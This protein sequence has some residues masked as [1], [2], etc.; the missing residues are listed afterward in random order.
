MKLFFKLACL[1][2]AAA[3][4]A[5]AYASDG[6]VTVTGSVSGTT[7]TIVGNGT[8][9]TG[10]FTVALPKV[11]KS[12]LAAAGNTAGAVNFTIGVTACSGTSTTITPFFEGGANVNTSGR[13]SNAA[14]TGPATGVDV[15][16]LQGSNVVVMGASAGSQNVSAATLTSNAASVQFTAQYYA[17]AAAT[18]GAYSSSF[19]YSIAY[20]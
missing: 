6:T 4:V 15:Q 3:S 5:S 17:T 10:S 18:A 7:C 1:G 2:V 19:T 8:S 16:I 20:N 14:T 12:D 9:G 13:L 11:S